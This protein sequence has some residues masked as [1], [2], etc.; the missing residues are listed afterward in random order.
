MFFYQCQ[1]QSQTH[2]TLLKICNTFFDSF[3]GILHT[4]FYKVF[5]H[6]FQ[7]FRMVFIV[8]KH[9][10]QK[11]DYFVCAVSLATFLAAAAM[12]MNMVMGMSFP[13]MGNYIAIFIFY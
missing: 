6:L 4:Q 13:A 5:C 8:R 11:C 3:C 2:I 7:L 10:S 9:I 1:S 12:F